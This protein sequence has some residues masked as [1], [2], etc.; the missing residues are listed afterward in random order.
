MASRKAP[1]QIDI[2]TSAPLAAER[3]QPSIASESLPCAA[4]TISRLP[5]ALISVESLSF[6]SAD[7]FGVA[8][9]AL[10]AQKLGAG[11]VDEAVR[12]TRISVVDAVALLTTVG[13]VFFATRSVVLPI[14][15]PEADVIAAG[16]A[17]VPVL[18]F[19]QPF[20]ATSVVVAEAL[21]GGGFTR[22]VLCVSALSAFV[23]RLSCTWLFAITWGLGLTGVWMGSTADWIV[24]TALLVSLGTARAR[25]LRRER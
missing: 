5:Q 19:A 6:L 1:V 21:R 14:F 16:A 7:G 20:M 22:T 4:I 13:V 3:I 2:V 25:A 8:A 12:V 17:A 15:T 23:V 24:R 11:R 9:A 10:V 18:A